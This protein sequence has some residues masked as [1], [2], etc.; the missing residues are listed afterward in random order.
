MK[1]N[2]KA[3]PR[4]GTE[5]P[6]Y[7]VLHGLRQRER[8]RKPSATY[9]D[10]RNP[11]RALKQAVKD[12][13]A[14]RIFLLEDD[15]L[16]SD[17]QIKVLRREF[18]NRLVELHETESEFVAALPGLVEYPPAVF[19]LDVMLRWDNPGQNIPKPDD[20]RQEGFY[21]AGLRCM[22]LIRETPEL[23]HIPIVLYTML[24]EMDLRGMVPKDVHHISKSSDTSKLLETLRTLLEKEQK[25]AA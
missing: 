20:V 15:Y 16:Q 3:L 6:L 12:W 17:W 8:G 10:I 23:A 21:R 13:H 5:H 1:V 14:S 11:R 9:K 19:I 7:V 22:K 25:A 4:L 24:E 2:N 18:P